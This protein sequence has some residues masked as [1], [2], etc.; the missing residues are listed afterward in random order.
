MQ[1]KE[2]ELGRGQPEL[3]LQPLLVPLPPVVVPLLP[4]QQLEQQLASPL[5]LF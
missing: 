1:K 3:S 5:P 2:L 4:P